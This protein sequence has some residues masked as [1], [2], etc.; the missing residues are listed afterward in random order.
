MMFSAKNLSEKKNDLAPRLKTG[1]PAALLAVG[2][3]AYA[4]PAFLG[5]VVLLFAVVG[6]YEFD[7]MLE[8]RNI[9]LNLLALLGSTIFLTTATIF[10][11]IYG[12]MGALAATCVGLFFYHLIFLSPSD[13]SELRVLGLS[14][15]GL[16]WISWSLNH[17]TLIKQLPEGTALL[18]LLVLSIWVSDIAA[19]FGGR[20]FGRL[21]LALTISPKKTIEGSIC[22]VLGTAVVAIVFSAL[23][24]ESM[25]WML[26]TLVAVSTAIVGQIG[27]LLE[28]KIK[29]LCDVEDSGTIFPGHGGVLDRMD[30]FLTATP[31][32]YYFMHWLTQ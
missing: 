14:L 17:F 3:I 6:I 13:V 19:Y 1:I 28:S 16:L 22:G 15:F 20:T 23:F 2:I 4:P 11:G 10:G 18:F 27:D 8:Q 7:T 32:F 31:L 29:R 26:A 24:L 5:L 25:G 9:R 12:V 21:P 30:G